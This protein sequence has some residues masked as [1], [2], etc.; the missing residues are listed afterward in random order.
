M[1][2]F[3]GWLAGWLD[4]WILFVRLWQSSR[5]VSAHISTQLTRLDGF[6][7][8]PN[9]PMLQWKAYVATEEGHR[10]SSSPSQGSAVRPPRKLDSFSESEAQ[11]DGCSVLHRAANR[12]TRLDLG[13]YPRPTAYNVSAVSVISMSGN[14]NKQS[15]PLWRVWERGGG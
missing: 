13:V 12:T 3:T 7:R 2:G 1:D 6:V 14:H 8:V 9:M 4:G 11:S 10:I 5:S 15:P